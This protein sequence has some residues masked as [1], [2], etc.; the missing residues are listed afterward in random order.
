MAPVA[1]GGPF[2]C[3]NL[4]IHCVTPPCPPEQDCSCPCDH[5]RLGSLFTSPEHAANLISKLHEPCCCER[6]RAVE[7]L[8]NRL[9][10]DFCKEPEV[11]N[12]LICAM[13][14]DPC[15]EV[16]RAAAWALHRQGARVDQAVVALYVSSRMDPHYLVRDKAKEALDILLL[17]HYECYRCFFQSGD[18]LIKDLK[19]AGY[20]PGTENCHL[21]LGGCMASCCQG[22]CGLGGMPVV[23]AP[24]DG[25][26][27]APGA[28]MPP[29]TDV[30]KP[31]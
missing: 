27:V 11:L 9:R 30:K 22:G 31:Q 8:G 28:P 23:T 3:L 13:Q 26:L 1:W 5:F 21:M 16:R 7:G 4:G 14:C 19:K 12:A 17:G 29:A 15:W 10:A 18:Q 24:H 20:K 2:Q 25:Q 6:I